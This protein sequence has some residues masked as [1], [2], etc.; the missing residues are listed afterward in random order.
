M[1]FFPDDLEAA[2]AKQNNR[3]VRLDKS[4]E[5]AELILVY[6]IKTL[7]LKK[8][9]KLQSFRWVG[10]D[11]GLNNAYMYFETKVPGGLSGAQ[12]RNHFLFE[13]FDDQVNVVTVK[14]D[15]KQADLV[16]RKEDGKSFKLIP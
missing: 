4:K 3:T 7:E 13:M 9:E 15:G 11:L 5:V 6:L 16:F 10:M 8:G 12:I 2:L 1:R 14:Y